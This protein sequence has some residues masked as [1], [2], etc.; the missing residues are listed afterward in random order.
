MLLY[1]PHLVEFGVCGSKPSCLLPK[2][3][4]ELNFEESG[5]LLVG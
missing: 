1:I 5:I 2:D 4:K 3:N